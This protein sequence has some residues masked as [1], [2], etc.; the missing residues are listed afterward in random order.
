MNDIR[1][2]FGLGTEVIVHD[3]ED[4]QS[5]SVVSS[6]SNS[7]TTVLKGRKY[8]E[9]MSNLAGTFDSG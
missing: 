1:P 4:V 2:N 3:F 7:E 6:K 5:V 8:K 9:D